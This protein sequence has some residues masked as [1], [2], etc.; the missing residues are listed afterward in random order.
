MSRGSNLFKKRHYFKNFK[1]IKKEVFMDL[2]I[3]GKIA[4]VTGG[5]KGLGKAVAF[6]L[7]EEGARLAVCARGEKDLND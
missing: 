7:A 4:V 1:N 5:S 6:S 2:G 3:K